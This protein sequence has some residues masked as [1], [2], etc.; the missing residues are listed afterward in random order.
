MK[1]CSTLLI[2]REMQIKT[3]MS[4]T[5]HW[6]VWPSLTSLQITNAGETIEKM[7]PS[8]TVDGNVNWCSHYGEQFEVSSKN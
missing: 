6:S 3:T 2:M 8:Y 5:S 4:S 1:R 7:E